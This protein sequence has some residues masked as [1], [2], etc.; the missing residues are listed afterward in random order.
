[1][2][3]AKDLETMTLQEIKDLYR[4]LT[5]PAPV[6]GTGKN[7]C[8][9]K[10]DWIEAVQKTVE[11]EPQP[12][13]TEWEEIPEHEQIPFYDPDYTPDE[14]LPQ[15]DTQVYEYDAEKNISQL[16]SPCITL[17]A[18]AE[19]QGY[20]YCGSVQ[21][22]IYGWEQDRLDYSYHYQPGT[23]T[24]RIKNKLHQ[25]SNK[26]FKRRKSVECR[27][28]NRYAWH[29]KQEDVLNYQVWSVLLES[30]TEQECYQH[31]LDFYGYWERKLDNGDITSEV[32]NEVTNYLSKI[33]DIVSNKLLSEETKKITQKEIQSITDHEQIPHNSDHG[34]RALSQQEKIG[35]PISFG[36]TCDRLLAGIKTVTRRTWK[37]NYAQIF[38]KAYQQNKLVPAFDKDRRYGGKLIGYL[39]L[40]CEPC[41]ES[42]FR[43]TDADVKAEGFPELSRWSFISEFFYAMSH[44]ATDDE[45]AKVWV[46]R[47]EFYP[48]ETAEDPAD[49]AEELRNKM[50]CWHN[51]YFHNEQ[52]EVLEKYK[53]EKIGHASEDSPFIGEEPYYEL[54]NWEVHFRADIKQR[55]P[56]LTLLSLVNYPKNEWW[57]LRLNCYAT[58]RNREQLKRFAQRVIL[59]IGL[60]AP[61]YKVKEGV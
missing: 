17:A 35:T 56:K 12:E 49:I 9:I 31:Y 2:T 54:N 24:Q 60:N 46:V 18:K 25:F 59:E 13:V 27:H 58:T 11:S 26:P 6:V 45:E 4:G 30:K 38:I 29:R 51:F 48:L 42:I 53:F 15:E 14:E 7:G 40:A 33:Y 3:Q 50:E 43:M 34:Y 37:D 21:K 1:M 36:W 8:K 20:C 57:G 44:L 23:I 47:F 5:N 39:K 10:K 52:K 19:K 41:K 61:A 16:P 22:D 28:C 32:A 55:P